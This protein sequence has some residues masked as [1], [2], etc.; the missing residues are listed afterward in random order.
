MITVFRRVLSPCETARFS[1]GGI[2]PGKIYAFEDADTGEVFEIRADELVKNGLAVSMP[3]K[4]SSKIYFY[5][6]K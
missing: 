2:I 1:L 3:Q 4:R 5:T 6:V